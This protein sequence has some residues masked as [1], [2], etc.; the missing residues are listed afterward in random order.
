MI[1]V[2]NVQANTEMI[3]KYK[4]KG[5]ELTPLFRSIMTKFKS[6]SKSQKK[7][8][9]QVYHE[10]QLSLHDQTTETPDENFEAGDVCRTVSNTDKN[11]ILEFFNNM[12]A[13]EMDDFMNKEMVRFFNDEIVYSVVYFQERHLL[14]YLLDKINLILNQHG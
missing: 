12:S 2:T 14:E 9:F 7:K 3:Q 5:Q 13:K 6:I 1:K 4:D 10:L 8:F 11:Q